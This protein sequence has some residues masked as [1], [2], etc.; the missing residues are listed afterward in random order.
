GRARREPAALACRPARA[1]TTRARPAAPPA[2]S[3]ARPRAR[4]AS[5]RTAGRRPPSP[6]LGS[7][8]RAGPD[9]R[10]PPAA[11][12]PAPAHARCA[13]LA[14]GAGRPLAPVLLDS[15]LLAEARVALRAAILIDRHGGVYVIPR[16]NQG[17]V[18]AP[19]SPPKIA[20]MANRLSR[21]ALAALGT[22]IPL[23]GV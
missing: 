11:G 9:A 8:T 5:L 20:R 23:V 12:A 2:S 16:R 1:R 21:A 18:D 6:D 10:H 3:R 15:L 4:G 7:R 22:I 17:Q 14:L 19:S 13:R